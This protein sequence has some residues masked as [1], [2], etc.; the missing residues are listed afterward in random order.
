[1]PKYLL[2]ANYVGDGVKGL[3]KDGGSARRAAA[4]KAIRSVGGTMEGFYFAFGDFDAIVLADMPDAAS[5]TAIALAINASGLV[6]TKT[7]ALLTSE[8]VDMAVKKTTSY[9]APGQ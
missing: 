7:I 8:E 2:Q 9:R 4:D 6:A 1:M 3:L 5:M